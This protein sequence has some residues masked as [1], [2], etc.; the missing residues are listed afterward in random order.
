MRLEV[1]AG[2]RRHWRGIGSALLALALAL[3]TAWAAAAWGSPTATRA[4]W[5]WHRADP[6]AV[7]DWA[8]D[9]RVREIFTFVPTEL[10]A[11]GDLPRLADLKARADQVGIALSA[12]G[13]EPGWVFTPAVALAWQRAALDTGLFYRAHLDVE[14]Y[15]LNAWTTDQTG[16][17]HAYLDLL[18]SLQADDPRSLE[19]DVP[20]WYS[21]ISLDATNLADEVLSRV[22]AATV[23][24]YRDTATGTNSITDV[25]A[26]MLRR[27]SA[28]G[29]PVR[30][31]AETQPTPDCPYCTFYEEG[32]RYL[33]RTLARVDLVEHDEPAYNGVAVHQYLSWTQ[34]RP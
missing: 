5:L 15:L 7:I 2:W 31:G 34:L 12:L 8:V 10:P 9:H 13:G 20:F 11:S 30:L 4:M 28:V 6:A 27:G 24:S 14:P 23:M 19:V 25:G 3:T 1:R 21:T 26:D 32:R 29:K 33:T 18:A 17:A 22:D 16:T